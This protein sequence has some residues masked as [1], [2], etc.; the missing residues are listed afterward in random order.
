MSTPKTSARKRRAPNA[1]IR[2][3]DRHG[4]AIRFD[5]KMTF[6]ELLRAGVT[7]ISIRLPDVPLKENEYREATP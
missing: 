5:R 3:V 6:S 4:N 1:K 2:F 7:H